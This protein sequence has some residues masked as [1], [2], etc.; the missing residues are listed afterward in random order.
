MGITIISFK[1]KSIKTCLRVLF[2]YLLSVIILITVSGLTK[3][4]PKEYQDIYTA[5]LSSLLTLALVISFAKWERFRLDQAG[6][7]IGRYSLKRFSMGFLIGF[8]MAVL[9]MLITTLFAHQY[10][11]VAINPEINIGAIIANATLYLFIALREELVFRSYPLRALDKAFGSVAAL[12]IM[13]VLFIFEHIASGMNWG[14]AIIG[15]GLGGLLFGLA[16]LRTKGLALPLGLHSA[17][18]FGQ[19]STGFKNEIGILK[20][21]I[22]K[23]YEAHV[24][25]V[26]LGAFVFVMCAAI[27]FLMFLT[28]RSKLQENHFKY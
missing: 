10:L 24:K 25:N 11:K 12:S 26:G 1:R 23:G 15:S 16:A 21:V 2:F 3:R 17:W 8:L 9:Q 5:V 13:V 19:W 20:A 27:T 7:M 18:N 6:I 4:F 22:E 14:M 28:R